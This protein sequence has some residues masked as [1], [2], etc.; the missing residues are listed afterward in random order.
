MTGSFYFKIGDYANAVKLLKTEAQDG[1]PESMYLIGECY[2]NGRGVA[3]DHGTA[4]LWYKASAEQ[5]YADAQGDLAY[6]LLKGVCKQKVKTQMK[7][8]SQ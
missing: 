7:K 3:E 6:C 2:Y 4:F 5:G 1:N 8:I